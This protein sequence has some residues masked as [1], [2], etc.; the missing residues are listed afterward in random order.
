MR[1]DGWANSGY[2]F[3]MT[4]QICA[5]GG[6]FFICS[7]E[8]GLLLTAEKERILDVGF[9]ETAIRLCIYVPEVQGLNEALRVLS[10]RGETM[11]GVSGKSSSVAA[12]TSS[13]SLT[14]EFSRKH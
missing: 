4:S 11:S 8:R 9:A 1:D 2:G 12:S 13:Q 10:K 6:S 14:E 7:G 5:R 3:F